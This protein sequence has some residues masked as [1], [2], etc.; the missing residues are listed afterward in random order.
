MNKTLKYQP[1]LI[2]L[3]LSGKKTLTW[4]VADDKN[5]TTGD[6]VDFLDSESKEKFATAKLTAIKE[7]SFGELTDEDWIGHEKFSSNDEMYA[8]YSKIYNQPVKP[9]TKLKI[10]NFELLS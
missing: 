10:I 5:L 4:R 2:P 1:H 7:K 6:I 8:H 3:I 9:D